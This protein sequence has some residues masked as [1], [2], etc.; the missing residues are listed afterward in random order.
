[1]K[2]RGEI[3]SVNED[4]CSHPSNKLV[5]TSMGIR[6]SVCTKLMGKHQS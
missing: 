3:H 4:T 6:C 1:M 2:D 5:L